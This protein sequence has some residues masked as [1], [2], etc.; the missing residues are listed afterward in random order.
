MDECMVYFDDISLTFNQHL[1]D[2]VSV[3]GNLCVL[4]FPSTSQRY[5]TLVTWRLQKT[6][7]LAK[8]TAVLWNDELLL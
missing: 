6:L 5:A 4:V 2:L 3:L 7:T 1:T 8:C